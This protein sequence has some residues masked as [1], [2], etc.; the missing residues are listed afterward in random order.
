MFASE[1]KLFSTVVATFCDSYPLIF[2]LLILTPQEK[3][4]KK[5]RKKKLCCLVR[6]TISL[7]GWCLIA[8]F[9]AADTVEEHK[10]VFKANSISSMF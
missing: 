2:I 6:T 3:E 5:K 4:K 9:W 10:Q 7:N 1:S 8:R